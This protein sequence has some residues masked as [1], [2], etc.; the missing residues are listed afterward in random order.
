MLVGHSLGGLYM[1]LFARVYPEELKALVLVD[2]LYPRSVNQP[3]SSTAVAVD[4]GAFRMDQARGMRRAQCT[5][6]R[7]RWSRTPVIRCR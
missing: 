5:R 3:T 7:K 4:F 2:A 6:K 1:Q